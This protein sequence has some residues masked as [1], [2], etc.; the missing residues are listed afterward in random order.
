MQLP[1]P[2]ECAWGAGGGVGG[3]FFKDAGGWERGDGKGTN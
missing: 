3:R 1:K 2:P